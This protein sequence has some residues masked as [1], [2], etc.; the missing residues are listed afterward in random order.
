V[1]GHLA[2]TDAEEALGRR[3]NNKRAQGIDHR[4][5]ASPVLATQ[6]AMV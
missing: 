5:E 1:F 6:V 4:G 3:M 2:K